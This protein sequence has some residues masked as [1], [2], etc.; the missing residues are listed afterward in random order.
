MISYVIVCV[1]IIC[2]GP[3]PKRSWVLKVISSVSKKF[4]A[5]KPKAADN[6]DDKDDEVRD[7]IYS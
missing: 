5:K 1:T 6:G 3:R 7:S 4:K 2:V